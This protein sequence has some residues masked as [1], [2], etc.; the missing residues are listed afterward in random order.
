MHLKRQCKDSGLKIYCDRGVTRRMSEYIHKGETHEE[1][2]LEQYH[3]AETGNFC[4]HSTASAAVSPVSHQVDG[5]DDEM[6]PVP[7]N[8]MSGLA[9]AATISGEETRT[10]DSTVCNSSESIGECDYDMDQMSSVIDMDAPLE[11]KVDI[12]A[13]R[14]KIGIFSRLNAS[15]FLSP[16]RSCSCS[17]SL[18]TLSSFI[19][20][21]LF[22]SFHTFA[23]L[24]HCLLLFSS[25]IICVHL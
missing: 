16:V 24:L 2:L 22:L 7:A 20:L 18:S 15:D 23:P 17:L 1:M 10:T 21:S 5:A 12:D 3:I 11:T 19:P 25:L 14:T 9:A 6:G 13:T 4:R 8:D